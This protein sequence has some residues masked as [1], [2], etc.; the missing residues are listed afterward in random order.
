M[1]MQTFIKALDSLA[2][3]PNIIGIIGGEPSYHPQ[4]EEMCA[5]IKKRFPKDKMGF[6]TQGGPAFERHRG[7][8]SE[9]FRIL[10]YNEHNEEQQS[11][12][13]HQPL[14]IAIKEAVPDEG[15]RS[16]LI[17]NC[18]VQRIWCPTINHF[19][20]YFCEVGAAQDV[21]LN[22]GRNAWPIKPGWWKKT[23]E[24][25]KDQVSALCGNCGMAIPMERELIC[26]KTEKFS[27]LLLQRFRENRLAKVSENDVEIFGH[28]FTKE[29][30]IRNIPKWY[31]GNYRGDRS[32]DDTCG[33]GRG[34]PGELA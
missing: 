19:G 5:E 15:T 3:W 28:A 9:T 10:A 7:L 20:A 31:P 16:Q 11:L 18:W 4:L 6:W 1:D 32:D 13:R 27:P 26:K 29:E 2:D 17:D 22:E 14:T 21:L 24:Q 12:C 34:F 23:P 25:F 8:I 33:E 30:L